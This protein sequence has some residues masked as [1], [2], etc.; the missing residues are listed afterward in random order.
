MKVAQKKPQDKVLDKKHAEF[1][2]NFDRDYA[3]WLLLHQ[4]NVLLL[5]AREKELSKYRL[6]FDESS[7]L[8]IISRFEGPPTVSDISHLG[9]RGYHTISA[10][11]HRMEKRGLLKRERRSSKEN[12]GGIRLTEK[13]QEALL[14]SSKRESITAT[15]STVIEE[16]RE[17]F[18]NLLKKIRDSAVLYSAMQ[19]TPDI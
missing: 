17:Q 12:P 1:K 2:D 9:I 15:M 18:A 8:G 5:K 3:L 13:G 4:T 6:T 11:I 14:L 19:D 16:E 10:L 7:T